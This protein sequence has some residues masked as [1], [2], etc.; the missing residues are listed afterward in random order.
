MPDR[1]GSTYDSSLY[2][3]QSP[4]IGWTIRPT[5]TNE[6]NFLMALTVETKDCTALSDAELEEMA[7]LIEDEP[8]IFDVGELSKQRDAWVLIT[9][10]RD[11]NK[12]AAYGFCTLE[13][14]GGDPTVLIGLAAVRRTSRRDSALKAMITD[15]MRRAVLAFP[16]EDVLVAAQ[17]S[18]PAAFDAYRP[19]SRIV[20]RPGYEANGEDRAWGRRLAKRFDVR[21][22]YKAKEFRVY[23]EGLPSLVLNHNSAKPES[24][25]TEISALF[26]GQDASKGDA[27]VTFGWATREKL[28]KLL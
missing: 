27:L 24:I 5:C 21:G 23:G 20:P 26:E 22:E 12:L 7:D 14:V 19:L 6:G 8:I 10:V 13:R 18:D 25:K 9:Q 17:M 16:D 3:A 15:Q 1:V 28:A 4:I 2:F 11:G